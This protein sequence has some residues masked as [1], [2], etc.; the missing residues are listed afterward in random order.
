MN[1]GTGKREKGMGIRQGKPNPGR[2]EK[3]RKQ[4]HWVLL[5]QGQRLFLRRALPSLPPP[6]TRMI[7]QSLGRNVIIRHFK[8]A[9]GEVWDRLPER[10]HIAP[11]SMLPQCRSPEMRFREERLERR[12]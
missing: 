12:R 10:K 5:R 6:L 11:M 3:G 7:P 9:L 2:N 1:K 4:Y 8:F